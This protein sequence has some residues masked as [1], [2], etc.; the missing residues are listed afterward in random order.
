AVS[1]AA[2]MFNKVPV[3]GK[4]TVAVVSG[5]NIDVNILNRVITRGLVKSGR[6][7]TITIDLS[8]KPGEL[9]GVCAVL[10]ANGANILS[11]VHERNTDRSAINDCLLRVEI[12]TRNHEHVKAIHKALAEAGYTVI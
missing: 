8:D 12:E 10:G 2:V 7:C 4:K 11:V 3:K 9:S 1:V 5:G 6:D